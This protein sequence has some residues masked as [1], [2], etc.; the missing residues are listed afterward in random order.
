MQNK[1]GNLIQI[2]QGEN[3]DTAQVG[4]C[5]ISA[6]RLRFN[7]GQLMVDEVIIGADFF[8]SFFSYSFLTIIPLLLHSNLLSSKA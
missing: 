7:L 3:H 8:L 2:Y 4:R 6:W 5:W 1:K